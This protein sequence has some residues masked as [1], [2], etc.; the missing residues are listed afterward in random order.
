VYLTY[1]AIGFLTLAAAS[2]AAPD[3]GRAI[4]EQAAVERYLST[5]DLPAVAEL[6]ALSKV[7]E[8]TLMAIALDLHAERLTRS[9]AVAALRLLPSPVVQEFLAKLIQDK[10]STTDPTER[11][12]L[13]R[14]AVALGWMAGSDAP[15]RLAQLFENQDPEVRL[16]A[17]LGIA[18]SRAMNAGAVLRR[19]LL[20]ETASRV[21][22]QIRRQLTALGEPAAEP[23]K[24]P[25]KKK[26]ERP[27]M[28]SG[29]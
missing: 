26:P 24:A 7:P 3:A 23:D 29:F 11:L 21:R 20:V 18:M 16:D 9:R 12:L 13:R 1:L 15:G 5:H 28:R 4:S 22:D 2:T 10:A 25:S 19:H 6:D 27:P 14:A 17:V 8:K